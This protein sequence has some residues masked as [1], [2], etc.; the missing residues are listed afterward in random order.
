M[1]ANGYFFFMNLPFLKPHEFCIMLISG[2][3]P[4]HMQKKKTFLDFAARHG[5]ECCIKVKC[6]TSGYL[7]ITREF[8]L[9]KKILVSMPFHQSTDEIKV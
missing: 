1:G 6:S 9:L 8:N 7:S 4:D 2:E 5:G 3:F